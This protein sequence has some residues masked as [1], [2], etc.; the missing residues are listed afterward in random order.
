MK[1]WLAS[2]QEEGEENGNICGRVGNV[3]GFFFIS[4]LFVACL[5]GG[6]GFF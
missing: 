5:F 3:L 4:F 1:S 6:F 2:R